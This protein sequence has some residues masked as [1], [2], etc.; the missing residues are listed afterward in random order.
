MP[1]IR[2]LDSSI[3][4]R[5]GVLCQLGEP[6]EGEDKRIKQERDEHLALVKDWKK[7]VGE[8]DKFYHEIKSG[9]SK[10]SQRVIGEVIHVE[11]I[12]ASVAPHGFSADW[13]LI[14]LYND[15]FDWDTF[16]GNK[17]YIGGNLS[18]EYGST[19]FPQPEDRAK[20][21]CPTDGLLQAF[22]VIQLEEI[23]NP[24]Q[25]DGNGESCLLVVK[26]GLATG[27]TIGRATGIESFTRINN[28]HGIEETSRAIA[29]LPYS[30]KTSSFSAS[31][32]KTGPFS[33]SGDS[34]SIVLDRN[35]RI[36]GMITAGAGVTDSTDI[37]YVTPYWHIEQEIKKHFPE[38][39]LYEVVK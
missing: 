12:E 27:T 35:G 22:G 38:S 37:T 8:I 19:M 14:E 28:E 39:F 26:N 11:P 18:S 17:V 15:K 33:A 2:C 9:W 32:N 20:Y 31:R 3:R 24:Q 36:L 23:N 4:V 34:G 30:N 6:E 21:K 7:E 13:A 1:A 10:P 5:Q 16:P 25:L 29:V